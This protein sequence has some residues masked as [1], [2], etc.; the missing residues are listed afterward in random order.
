MSHWRSIALAG[1][2]LSLSAVV[3][4]AAGSHAMA[5]TDDLLRYRAWQ[6]ALSMHLFHALGLLALAALARGRTTRWFDAGAIA[7]IVGLLLF[8]G[9]VYWRVYTGADSSGPL[10]PLGGML[11]MTGWIFTLIGLTRN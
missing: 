4:A 8:C 5:V 10:A 2:V 1:A 11:L 9:S 7:M 6:S 3:T